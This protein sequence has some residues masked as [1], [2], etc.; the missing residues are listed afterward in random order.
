MLTYYCLIK[1]K[2]NTNTV[3]VKNAIKS[4]PMMF[5]L[6]LEVMK[7]YTSKINNKNI[8]IQKVYPIIVVKSIGNLNICVKENRTQNKVINTIILVDIT[9]DFSFKKLIN[10][11]INLL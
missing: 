6:N 2:V 1:R 7:K 10:F 8:V 11:I 5:F 4:S 3:N 9:N